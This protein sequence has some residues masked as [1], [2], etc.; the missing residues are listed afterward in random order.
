MAGYTPRKAKG[1]NSRGRLQYCVLFPSKLWNP[2]VP[3]YSA[4][5]HDATS[6]ESGGITC[7]S[8]PWA[9][10]FAV[11][12]LLRAVRHHHVWR[13]TKQSS[14][15]MK[16]DPFRARCSVRYK[17]GAAGGCKPPPASHWV[18]TGTTA[19]VH[20]GAKGRE[21]CETHHKPLALDI[22]A[23]QHAELQLVAFRSRDGQIRNQKRNGGPRRGV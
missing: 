1:G 23:K 5:L 11:W 2:N 10:T 21:H 8:Y 9:Q 4:G 19:T 13:H 6:C 16:I 15:R 18:T 17:R 20:I 14:E 12:V 22:P 3:F 7:D